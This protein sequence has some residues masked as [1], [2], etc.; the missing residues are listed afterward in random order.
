MK[1]ILSEVDLRYAFKPGKTLLFS[2]HRRRR[3]HRQD[4]RAEQC[5]AG[6]R[7]RRRHRAGDRHAELPP[8]FGGSLSW[9]ASATTSPAKFLDGHQSP[10]RTSALRQV[11]NRLGGEFHNGN[12]R[13]VPSDIL[14]AAAADAR[15]PL[16]EQLTLRECALLA[17]AVMRPVGR[18]AGVAALVRHEVEPRCCTRGAA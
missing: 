2:G 16:F 9:S 12:K 5:A 11:A 15:K 3:A 6:D 13:R 8:S 10:A 14:A 1:H 4:W 18:V 17:I 7:Q